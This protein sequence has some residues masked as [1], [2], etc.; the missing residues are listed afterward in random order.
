MSKKSF[1]ILPYFPWVTLWWHKQPFVHPLFHRSWRDKS[2]LKLDPTKPKSITSLNNWMKS[3]LCSVK[4]KISGHE[5]DAGMLFI[6]NKAPVKDTLI[7]G[8]NNSI[9]Y[10]INR[11][12]SCLYCPSRDH[13]TPSISC[14][15]NPLSDTCREAASGQSQNIAYISQKKD[16]DLTTPLDIY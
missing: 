1:R 13:S 4:N 11:N 9:V 14:H 5:K 15:V 3:I 10:P 6:V 12:F 7:T 2:L 16:E 8:P